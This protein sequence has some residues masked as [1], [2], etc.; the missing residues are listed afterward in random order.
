LNSHESGNRLAFKAVGG[1]FLLSR[2][3]VAIFVYLGHMQRPY[4]API[5]GGWEGV[6]NWWL[7]PWTTYDSKHF[8]DIAAHGY[9]AHNAPFFPLYAFLLRLAGS[10]PIAVA[11]WG[12]LL[13]N[14]AFL[15]ALVYLYRLTELQYNARTARIIVLVTTFFPASPYFS[16]VYSESVFLLAF[17]GALW[18]LRQK[19]WALAALWGFLAAIT[20]SAGVLIFGGLCVQYAFE[21]FRCRREISPQAPANIDGNTNDNWWLRG[22]ATIAPLLGFI[23]AQGFIAWQVGDATKGVSAHQEYFRALTWPWLPIVR[24]LWDVVTLREL[25]IIMLLNLGATIL[26]LLLFWKYRRRQPVAYSVMLLGLLLMQLTYSHYS[27]PR[28]QSSLRLLATMIPFLQPLAVELSAVSW[29]PMRRALAMTL[30]LFVSALSAYLFGQKQ[31]L[32]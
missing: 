5:P 1:A 31:F 11:L 26:A 13:S 24:D 7:N 16:A 14:A 25:Q 22:A 6:A 15:L 18:C 17:V 30:V 29:P 9:N 2:L 19:Q 8:M 28:T 23:L 4:L 21:W 32:G 10:D 20:R 12:I 27:I 3:W